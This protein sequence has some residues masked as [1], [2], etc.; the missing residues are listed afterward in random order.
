MLKKFSSSDSDDFLMVAFLTFGAESQFHIFQPSLA[1]SQ[2]AL[3][4]INVLCSPGVRDINPDS[5]PSLHNTF[6]LVLQGS[7]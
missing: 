5:F 2:F 7:G 1:G 3:N 4:K 6:F